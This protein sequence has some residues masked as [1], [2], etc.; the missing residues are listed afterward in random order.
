MRSVN[1]NRGILEEYGVD[2][3]ELNARA[4]LLDG[5]GIKSGEGRAIDLDAPAPKAGNLV[6]QITSGASVFQRNLSVA[7]LAQVS[8]G[9]ISDLDVIFL[10]QAKD[11]FIYLDYP[12]ADQNGKKPSFVELV[13]R[14][15]NEKDTVVDVGGQTQ[16]IK[17]RGTLLREY[18]GDDGIEKLKQQAAAL[19]AD[20]A[21]ET[22]KGQQ[23]T[24]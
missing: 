13:E 6:P 12:V 11:A 5:L 3:A 10:N 16:V 19:D 2:I 14:A 7:S 15:L 20:D 21:N 1:S 18:L 4:K 22:G 8:G 9:K 17:G 23:F 24:P